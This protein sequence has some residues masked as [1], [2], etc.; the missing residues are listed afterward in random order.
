M[1]L[2]RPGGRADLQGMRA[3]NL[4][5]ARA[6]SGVGDQAG[7][8]RAHGGQVLDDLFT[9]LYL[10]DRAATVRTSLQAHLDVIVDL[11]WFGSMSRWMTGLSSRCLM[12][13]WWLVILAS[14]RGRLP[15]RGAFQFLGSIL[16]LA[17]QLAKLFVLG[18]KSGDFRLKLTNTLTAWIGF[19]AALPTPLCPAVSPGVCAMETGRASKNYFTRYRKEHAKHVLFERWRKAGPTR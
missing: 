4:A 3:A 13:V 18:A 10:G 8:V 1:H 14:K 5:T 16:E 17:D 2:G 15:G 6:L 9:G 7:D 19:H 12:L 11:R